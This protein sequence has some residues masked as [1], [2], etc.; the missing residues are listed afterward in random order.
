MKIFILAAV[1][2]IPLFVQAQVP[3]VLITSFEPFGGM[4]V[5]TT[6]EVAEV[7]KEKL[8][9]KK[10]SAE[11]CVL[12]V[13]YD[14]AAQSARHCYEQMNPKPDIVISLGSAGC[15]LRLETLAHNVDNDMGMKDNLGLSRM[16]QTIIPNGISPISFG[17]FVADLYCS[18]SADDRKKISISESP[19]GFVCNNTAYLLG[20]Y[21]SQARVRFT[22]M[23][24]P[25]EGCLVDGSNK[26][27]K[28]IGSDIADMVYRLPLF[29]NPEASFEK[30]F[31]YLP[32][33]DAQIIAAQSKLMSVVNED[34]RKCGIEFLERMNNVID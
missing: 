30:V 2:L 24:I 20:N 13:I 26:I 25:G 11:V 14:Q 21:F 8:G 12:P 5:N 32:K 33:N 10:I 23:H 18:Q 6:M 16:A 31:P 3:R 27:G 19:G 17:G 34:R 1:A 15:E 29:S 9:K 4:K 28:K 7:I 22:F